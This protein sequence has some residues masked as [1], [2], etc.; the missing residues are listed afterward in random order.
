MAPGEQYGN[1]S[2]IFES[3]DFGI[4]VSFLK[5]QVNP[6]HKD[7][8]CTLKSCELEFLKQISPFHVARLGLKQY[9]CCFH[10]KTSLLLDFVYQ[11]ST[12]K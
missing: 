8:V 5:K 9:F 4:D 1:R 11:L 12:S 6:S 7:I 2:L 3:M 10:N